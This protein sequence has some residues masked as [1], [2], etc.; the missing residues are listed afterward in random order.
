MSGGFIKPQKAGAHQ[1][2]IFTFAGPLKKGDAE[3]W[4]NEVEKLKAMF[5]SKVMGVTMQGHTTPPSRLPSRRKS[6]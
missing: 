2:V 6:R 5:G 1:V 4:N 3:K